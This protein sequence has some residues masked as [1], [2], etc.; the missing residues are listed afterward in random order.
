MKQKISTIFNYSK[1]ELTQPMINLLNRGLNFAVLPLKM[2]LTQVLVDFKRFERSAIW[3]E[4]WYGKEKNQNYKPPI[5]KKQKR[6]YP[7]NYSS[8][9]ELKNCLSAIKSEIMDPRNRNRSECNL[10]TE[11]LS[12]LK[13][14]IRLQR[15]RVIMIKPCD[16]GAGILILDFKL[17]MQACYEHLIAKQ[18]NENGSQDNYYDQVE[19]WEIERS[20]NKIRTVLQE[21]LDNKI[22]S[23]EEFKAMDPSEKNLSKFY[24]TFK[25]HKP[26]IPMTAPPPRPIISGSGSMTENLGV[27]IEHHIKDIANKHDTYLQDTP[28]FLRK[29]DKINQ[30]PKLPS[31]A[32]LVTIDAIG[33][34]TNIPQ[35]DGVECLKEALEER[36]EQTIPSEFIAKLMELALQHNLFEFNLSTWRQKIGTAMGVHPAPNYANIYLS[37]RIDNKI[38][39][40]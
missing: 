2:D 22:I 14:L 24:M 9:Q 19:E 32:M 39:E 12:A 25:V 3:H 18:T 29:I 27:Y 4:F 31:N 5:F 30:G 28:D 33:A 38:K 6:N 37:R 34:Y 23:D 7:K 21:G 26:H 40:L 20:K 36:K 10:P 11:E 35:N 17:Y 13:E 8:P 15:E 1:I 16:K